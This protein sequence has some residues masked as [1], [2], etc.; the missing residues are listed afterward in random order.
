[1][2]AAIK[3]TSC[4]LQSLANRHVQPDKVVPGNDLAQP[5]AVVV[6]YATDQRPGGVDGAQV[7]C[8]IEMAAHPVAAIEK[9]GFGASV[10]PAAAL[11]AGIAGERR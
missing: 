10:D 5:G 9:R 3:S 7:G 2:S 4:P 6:L 8:F 11:A 1:V